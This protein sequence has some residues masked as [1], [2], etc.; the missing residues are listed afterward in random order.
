MKLKYLPTLLLFCFSLVGCN[1]LEQISTRIAPT[2][3]Q[4]AQIPSTPGPKTAE[5]TER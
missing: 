2:N 4:I 3:T 5:N 1:A